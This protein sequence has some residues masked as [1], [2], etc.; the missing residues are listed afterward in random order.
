MKQSS[1]FIENEENHSWFNDVLDVLKFSD[2]IQGWPDIFGE[3]LHSSVKGS[4]IKTLSLFSG[5]GGLDIAFSD[6]GFNI[7]E[8]V[9]IEDKFVK[10]LEHNAKN[11]GK[12]KNTKKTMGSGLSMPHLCV[13]M[14][15]NGQTTKT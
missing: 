1:L 14:C 8:C 10:T 6:S 12:I 4:S 7:I 15:V 2:G 5:G 11:D 13:L 9:E 3:K